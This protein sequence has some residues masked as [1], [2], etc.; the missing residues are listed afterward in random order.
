[1]PFWLKS[2]KPAESNTGGIYTH[3]TQRRQQRQELVEVPSSFTSFA[4]YTPGVSNFNRVTSVVIQ[5]A[6]ASG[7]GLDDIIA[8]SPAIPRRPSA[9]ATLPAWQKTPSPAPW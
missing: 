9:A 5:F 3:Q 7:I 4:S 2:L 8:E 6:G 1:M